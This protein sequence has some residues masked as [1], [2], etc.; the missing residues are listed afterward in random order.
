MPAAFIAPLLELAPVAGGVE[1][2]YGCFAPVDRPDL[3]Q[4][5]EELAPVPGLDD[6]VPRD[7]VRNILHV[8][9][10]DLFSGHLLKT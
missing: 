3:V 1:R 4:G 7:P 8:A 10:G 9:A 5:R 2:V 6:M